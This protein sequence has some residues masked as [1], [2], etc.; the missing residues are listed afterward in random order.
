MRAR[1]LRA[2]DHVVTRYGRRLAGVAYTVLPNRD[3]M[4]AIV[5]RAIADVWAAIPEA[6]PDRPAE[7]EARLLGATARRAR[8]ACGR[9]HEVDAVSAARSLLTRLSPEARATAA[10][11]LLGDLSPSRA[12]AELGI[13]PEKALALLGEATAAMGSAAALR[14]ALARQLDGLPVTVSGDAVREA[15]IRPAKR[16]WRRFLPSG[17]GPER[18]G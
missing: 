11:S 17:L 9:A 5:A 12:A 1:D 15:L 18:R 16:G 3:E 10:L 8:E 14:D 2:V 7:L 13:A 6:S 4:Q